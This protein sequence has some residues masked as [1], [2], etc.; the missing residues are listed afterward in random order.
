MKFA[1]EEKRAVVDPKDW[2]ALRLGIGL[3]KVI[4]STAAIVL[5]L[6]LFALVIRLVIGKSFE[7]ILNG[8]AAV[9]PIILIFSVGPWVSLFDLWSIIFFRRGLDQFNRELPVGPYEGPDL[10]IS[11][12]DKLK[13]AY[14]MLIVGE[15]ILLF[16]LMILATV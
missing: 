15:S 2:T 3:I 14:P 5:Q 7:S 9:S 10:P 1:G 16:V 13:I 6:T 4:L 12:E 8:M 11:T